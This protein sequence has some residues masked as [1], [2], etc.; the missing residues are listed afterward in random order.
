MKQYKKKTYA[1]TVKKIVHPKHKSG[2]KFPMPANNQK[3]GKPYDFV[4][5]EVVIETHPYSY[6]EPNPLEKYA[7]KHGIEDGNGLRVTGV[8]FN[9]KNWR[10]TVSAQCPPPKC[11][12]VYE[13][14][15]FYSNGGMHMYL[16]LDIVFEGCTFH[17]DAVLHVGHTCELVRSHAGHALRFY[18]NYR[19]V[20]GCSDIRI[21]DSSFD[22]IL[23]FR[24]CNMIYME[25][26]H[27]TSYEMEHINGH[28]DYM[29]GRANIGIFII[30]HI[31]NLELNKCRICAMDVTTSSIPVM[32]LTDTAFGFIEISNSTI[33]TM[34]VQGCAPNG[35]AGAIK[36]H[37][38]NFTTAPDFSGSVFP[39]H[40]FPTE[41]TGKWEKSQGKLTL[42]KKVWFNRGI[43]AK[44]PF[45][46]HMLAESL[47]E[48]IPVIAR[49]RVP[50][51]T[52]RHLDDCSGKVRVAEATVDGFF[53]M[54][55]KTHELVEFKPG[56]LG[57]YRSEHDPMFRYANR[58]RIRPR[59]KF[60]LTDN[61]CASGIHGFLAPEDADCY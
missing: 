30:D 34:T 21:V 27:Q 48:R 15:H 32:K 6:T 49:L 43:L 35:H 41:C 12:I 2:P 4:A 57:S 55:G 31:G 36:A 51:G 47:Y 22:D 8:S 17:S 19:G 56:H 38:T 59:K 52:P 13:N 20:G 45:F 29:F 9:M 3:Q 16:P 23:S 58:K 24:H 28:T 26:V 37:Q 61:T 46:G 44:L 54:D 42:Y 1:K 14:C 50:E 39:V 7:M 10:D 25:N 5:G 60:D 33:D 40:F 11:R 18:D 53:T